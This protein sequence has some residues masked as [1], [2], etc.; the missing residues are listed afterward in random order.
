MP[1][2]SSLAGLGN[3]DSLTLR[4]EKRGESSKSIP[5]HTALLAA[6][7]DITR[8]C[9]SLLVY[10]TGKKEKK[11]RLQICVVLGNMQPHT[12][13]LFCSTERVQFVLG[14]LSF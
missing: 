11:E 7:S 3:A 13:T 1:L 9:F 4:E 8:F 14:I 5:C 10:L 2:A 12:L 6:N